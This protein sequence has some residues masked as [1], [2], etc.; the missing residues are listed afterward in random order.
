MAMLK[1][2]FVYPIVT[3]SR[4]NNV[5][6]VRA[7]QRGCLKPLPRPIFSIEGGFAIQCVSDD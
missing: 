4:L 6:C 7:L 3:I 2:T 5:D 1:L